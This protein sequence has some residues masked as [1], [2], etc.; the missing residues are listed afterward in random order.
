MANT[1]VV[2]WD[3]LAPFVDSENKSSKAICISSDDLPFDLE[4]RLIHE[5]GINPNAFDFYVAYPG[6]EESVISKDL[7]YE[8]IGTLVLCR[9]SS[10]HTRQLSSLIDRLKDLYEEN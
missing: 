1:L 6:K 5:K 8:I 10:Q 3:F 9:E 2:E 4:T 7:L